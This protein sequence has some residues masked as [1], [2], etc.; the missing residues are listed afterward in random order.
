MLRRVRVGTRQIMDLF[1]SEADEFEKVGFSWINLYNALKEL[2]TR[3]IEVT[4]A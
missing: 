2:N 3:E 4:N 1:V